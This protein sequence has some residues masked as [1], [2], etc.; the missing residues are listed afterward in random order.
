[1]FLE[2]E[3]MA[4]CI[5]WRCASNFWADLWG[6]PRSCQRG[7]PWGC[8][9]PSSWSCCTRR[10]SSP[11]SRWQSPPDP[12]I[13]EPSTPWK[14]PPAC[15]PR[16]PWPSLDAGAGSAPPSLRR[17]PSSWSSTCFRRTACTRWTWRPIS[18]PGSARQSRPVRRRS[19]HAWP[20]SSLWQDHIYSK[21][22]IRKLL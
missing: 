17:E 9:P 18:C 8:R 4:K 22:G 16:S 13:L 11:T 5:L 2:F 15:R 20:H 21:V 7:R 1:M 19:S 6:W 10:K 12:C 3:I 14:C